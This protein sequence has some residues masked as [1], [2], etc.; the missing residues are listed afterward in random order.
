MK[1]ACFSVAAM[2]FFPQ[3]DKSFAGGNS[4]NQAVRFRQLGHES[5]F[6]GALGTDDAGDRIE[7]LLRKEKVDVSHTRRVPGAT[8]SNK[9]LDDEMGERTGI[10]GAWNGGVYESFALND[11]DWDYIEACDIWATHA[12]GINYDQALSRKKSGNF[13][14]VDFLHFD[15]YELLFKGINSVDIAY[16][17]G[18]RR[19]LP[20]LVSISKDFGG[21]IVLTLGAEGSVAIKDGATYEQSALPLDPVLDTTGCG[22]AFQAGFSA[23]YFQTKDIRK[24]LVAGATLGRKAAS[25]YGG[26]PWNER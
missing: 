16:F 5:G 10:D 20:D 17:G 11:S 14:V 12:N 25:H 19:Q 26:V 18:V 13:L 3:R 15:T 21:I 9:L 7:E 23:E 8:A 24:A 4:L 1:I 6:L 2:D 22:D